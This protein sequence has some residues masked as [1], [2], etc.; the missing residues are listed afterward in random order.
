[1]KLEFF[2]ETFLKTDRIQNFIKILPVRAALVYA[3]GQ[4]DMKKLTV[5]FRNFAN[6]PKQV[7]S[8]YPPVNTCLLQTKRQTP[9]NAFIFCILVLRPHSLRGG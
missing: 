1:M 8:M 3:D 7:A 2:L 6:A 4:A 5:A 9:Q